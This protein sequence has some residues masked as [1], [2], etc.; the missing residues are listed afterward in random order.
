MKA[1]Q[2]K[3]AKLRDMLVNN[4]IAGGMGE[5]EGNQTM[6]DYHEGTVSGVVVA[7][8]LL[9]D[10]QQTAAL[11]EDATAFATECVANYRRGWEDGKSGVTCPAYSTPHYALGWKNATKEV[12]G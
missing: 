9:L 3:T 11:L 5:V 7:T 2:V 6:I 1:S 4:L 8:R 10:A 12:R